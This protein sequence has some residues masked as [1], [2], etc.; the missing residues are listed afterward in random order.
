MELKSEIEAI[1][2]GQTLAAAV[3]A[4]LSVEDAAQ[5]A[6]QGVE[7][8]RLR[9]PQPD[10]GARYGGMGIVVPDDMDRRVDLSVEEP[11]KTS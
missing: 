4:R 3:G 2:W 1:I 7:Q 10:M 8:L 9:I 6:D 11:C 5:R